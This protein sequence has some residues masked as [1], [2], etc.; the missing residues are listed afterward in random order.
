MSGVVVGDDV[1]RVDVTN[2]LGGQ[3]KAAS[4]FVLGDHDGSDVDVDAAVDEVVRGTAHP[5]SSGDV[6][7]GGV[8]VNDS[9]KAP[10]LGN[11]D[12]RRAR[13]SAIS[14]DSAGRSRCPPYLQLRAV[15]EELSPE[16]PERSG[17]G[18]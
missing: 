8:G 9:P 16:G 7:I 11:R 5:I 10:V 14:V 15:A 13:G 2:D 3:V 6:A 4:G 1:K 18:A 17:G 12:R